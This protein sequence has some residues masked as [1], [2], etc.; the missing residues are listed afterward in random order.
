MVAGRQDDSQTGVV[1][2]HLGE[3]IVELAFGRSRRVGVVEDVAAHQ[4]GVG[5]FLGHRLQQP[6]QKMT[7]LI[8]AV[9]AV[10]G[11]AKMPV[12]SMEYFHT[13]ASVFKMQIYE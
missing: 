2:R 3:E 9:V 12:G 10:E 4:Q 7:V 11:V 5:V 1:G 6:V 8:R 13:F